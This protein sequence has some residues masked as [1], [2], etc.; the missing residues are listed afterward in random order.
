MRGIAGA[1]TIRGSTSLCAPQNDTW[2]GA[3]SRRCVLTDQVAKL[4][5]R[6]PCKPAV[7]SVLHFWE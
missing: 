5:G 1:S 7:S 3:P 4:P 2:E 6:S